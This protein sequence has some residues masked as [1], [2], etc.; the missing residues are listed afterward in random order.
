MPLAGVLVTAAA[1]PGWLTKGGSG[2]PC[3]PATDAPGGAAPASPGTLAL[4]VSPAPEDAG[5]AIS[6]AGSVAASA[7]P[8]AAVGCN[9]ASSSPSSPSLPPAGFLECFTPPRFP[10]PRRRRFLVGDESSPAPA[11][12]APLPAS[13][14][15]P[16]WPAP[17][18]S[19]GHAS[20]SPS[21]PWSSSSPAVLCLGWSSRP[22]VT[23]PAWSSA[24]VPTPAGSCDAVDAADATAEM[25]L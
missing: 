10:R 24:P 16:L 17:S 20:P 14:P 22:P 3:E 11:S 19:Q 15:P 8:A 7:A 4:Q 2:C 25:A 1:P 18:P 6:V 9:P 5:G 23:S 21:P 13:P 12:L